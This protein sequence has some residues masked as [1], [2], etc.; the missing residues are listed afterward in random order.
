DVANL[1]D[2]GVAVGAHDADLAGR[3]TD[4]GVAA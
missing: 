2:G 4:L 1:T 3:Q